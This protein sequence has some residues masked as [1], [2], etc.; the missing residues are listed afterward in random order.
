MAEWIIIEPIVLSDHLDY[1]LSKRKAIL[2]IVLYISW[3]SLGL[4]LEQ[5]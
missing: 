1:M 2:D 3:A 5:F 4:V